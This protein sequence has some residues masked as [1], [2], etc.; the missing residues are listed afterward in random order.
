MM[1]IPIDPSSGLPIYRQI[2][3]QLRRMIA[4]G[5]LQPGDRVPSV[6]D[7]SASLRINHLTVGKAYGEL[8]REGLLEKRRGLGVFVAQPDPERWAYCNGELDQKVKLDIWIPPTRMVARL[9]NDLVA[10]AARK[11]P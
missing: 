2:M 11:K 5:A 6:R 7:L 3:D 8:E 10:E 4:S 1:F 9:V